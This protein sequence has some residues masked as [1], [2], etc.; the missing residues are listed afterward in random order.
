M[1]SLSQ[2]R[3]ANEL[4]ED[5][6]SEI[7]AAFVGGTSGVGE[8]A[9][10]R[11]ASCVRKPEIFIVGRNE[12]SAARVLAELRNANPQG[13]YQFVKVDISLLRNVDRACEAIRHKTQTLDL[14]F[15]SA[16]SA[17]VAREDT[18]EGLEKNLVERY[19]ARMR[20]TQS[21]L[22]LLQASNKSPRVVSVLLGGF[23]IELE[24]DN[25]DLTKPR[26]AIYSTRHA[27]TMTSLSME[28]LATVYRSISFVHIYPGMVKTPLL[29]KGL[30]RFL[31]RI[32]WIL[33]W[34]FSIT[35]EQSGQYNVYMATS[36]AYPPL[37]PE[38][39]QG[40]GA[41][42]AEGGEICIGSTGKVGAGSYILNY[43]GA[44]R[45]NVKLMEGYRVR[46]YAQHIW[47]HTLSTFQ[48]VTGSAEPA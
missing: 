20:F 23:E 4:L 18:E 38:N 16:G 8:E 1:P 14:L 24:T 10:K 32:A 42:L 26:T 7:V 47:T 17:L 41:S 22:P 39:Q 48:T 36:A 29:D 33:Y 37:S 46:D 30:G 9:A 43:D 6:H 27:A 45:T 34:P 19:Y 3:Q 25:L 11:L 13:S 15:I 2:I 31:A 40:A 44:N 21:L 12:E 28:H 35:L 5:S